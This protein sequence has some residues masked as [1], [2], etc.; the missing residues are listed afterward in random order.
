MDT[1]QKQKA[2][3]L[4]GGVEIEAMLATGKA[5][6]VLVRQIP[7]GEWNKAAEV[8]FDELRFLDLV[9]NRAAGW[10]VGLAPG[11]VSLLTAK[12]EEVNADFFGYAARRIQRIQRYMPDALTTAAAA[13]ASGR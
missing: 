10:S 2:A 8:M 7:V 3:A 5:E 6:A 9:C 4:S 12:A 13:A 1:E 11:S